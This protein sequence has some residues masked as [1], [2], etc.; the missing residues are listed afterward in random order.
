MPSGHSYRLRLPDSID[1]TQQRFE[2]LARQRHRNWC[3][4]FFSFTHIGVQQHERQHS[5]R[6]GDCMSTVELPPAALLVSERT[7]AAM[8]GVSEKT[9]YNM[10]KAGSLPAVYIG[11]AKR[12]SVETL[13][14]WI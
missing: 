9:V 13:K 11:R 12:Y 7:A 3:R 10:T 5:T 4:C 14:R 1:S 2:V 8:L 6:S